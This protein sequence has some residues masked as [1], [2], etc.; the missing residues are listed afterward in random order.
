MMHGQLPFKN[1]RG[2]M[3][4]HLP[5]ETAKVVWYFLRRGDTGWYEITGSRKKGIG[6]EVPC[7][8]TFSG[9]YKL[10]KNP[11]SEVSYQVC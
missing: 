4:G 9:P 11:I 10:V 6:L 3:V 7:V 5:Q 2:M 1:V 8:Y